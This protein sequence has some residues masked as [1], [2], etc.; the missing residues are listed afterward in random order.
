VV[1]HRYSAFPILAEFDILT[2]AGRE[3]LGGSTIPRSALK[4]TFKRSLLGTS[5]H[6]T[7]HVA[8]LRE[9]PGPGIVIKGAVMERDSP[10]RGKENQ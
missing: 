10:P 2:S 3:E 7:I 8:W 1:V 6:T 9:D 4:D 5:S